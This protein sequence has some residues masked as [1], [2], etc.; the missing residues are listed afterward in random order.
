MSGGAMD[1]P[2]SDTI[3]NTSIPLSIIF[4]IAGATWTA[5]SWVNTNLVFA[6]DFEAYQYKMDE[7]ILTQ[8]KMNIENK[9]MEL[10]I[11]QQVLPKD[12]NAVDRAM[13]QRYNQQYQDVNEEIRQQHRMIQNKT[14]SKTPPSPNQ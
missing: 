4:A 11:K 12:F 1:I 13:L 8:Q 7:R 6:S 9:V 14:T 3:K 5:Y 2:F 10:Q